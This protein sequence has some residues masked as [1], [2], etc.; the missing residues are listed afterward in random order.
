MLLGVELPFVAI[1]THSSSS[2][3][4]LEL[5]ANWTQVRVLVVCIFF[6]FFTIE[7]SSKDGIFLAQLKGALNWWTKAGFLFDLW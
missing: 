3:K 5:F 1:G 2:D 6:F 7:S 4:K